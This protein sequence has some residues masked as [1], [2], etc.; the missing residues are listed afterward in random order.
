MARFGAYYQQA[1][2]RVE[3]LL[4]SGTGAIRDAGTF[5]VS[6]PN[7][8]ASVVATTYALCQ[9]PIAGPPSVLVAGGRVLLTAGRSPAVEEGG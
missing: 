3:A 8:P 7:D 9:G 6:V 1:H 4:P 2:A 5:V